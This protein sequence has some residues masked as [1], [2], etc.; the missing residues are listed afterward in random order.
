MFAFI[1]ENQGH[2][3]GPILVSKL[4]CTILSWWTSN[5]KRFCLTG[6]SLNK[7]PLK[8]RSLPPQSH[9]SFV[10]PVTTSF[11]SSHYFVVYILKQ[12]NFMF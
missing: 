3:V 4:Y 9:T 11:S 5:S 12:V 7:E 1:T 8:G 6:F 2:V 10:K